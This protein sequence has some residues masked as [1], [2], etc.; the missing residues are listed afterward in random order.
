MNS[1]SNKTFSFQK[2]N[3]AISLLPKRR[4]SI[5]LPYIF[6]MLTGH[7]L[8]VLLLS[9]LILLSPTSTVLGQ[10]FSDKVIIPTNISASS[11]IDSHE[12]EKKE[13]ILEA[14]RYGDNTQTSANQYGMLPGQLPILTTKKDQTLLDVRARE[15]FD[16][17]SDETNLVI[18]G[19]IRYSE[20][21][22]G[23]GSLFIDTTMNTTCT[24]TGSLFQEPQKA[25]T[26]LDNCADRPLRRARVEL[27]VKGFLNDTFLFATKTDDSGDFLFCLHNEPDNQLDFFINVETCAD[28]EGKTCGNLDGTP[29]SFSIVTTTEDDY[30]YT[31]STSKSPAENVCTGT[32][33]WNI[34]DKRP[35]NNGG[36]HIFDL[37][38]N[39]AFDY[40]KNKV[41]WTNNFRLQ[42]RFPASKTGF[43]TPDGIVGIASGDEQD[44]DAILKA[45]SY[46][47]LYQLYG[48][49]F[50]PHNSGCPGH[51]W[52]VSSD[53]GCAWVHGWAYFLQAAMQDDPLFI[54]T[55]SQGAPPDV[56]I[57]LEMP[58]PTVIGGIKD[59]GAVAATLWDIMDTAVEN[60]DNFSYDFGDIW[61]IAQTKPNDLCEFIYEFEQ[62]YSPGTAL[63]HIVDHHDVSCC[64]ISLT[65]DKAPLPPGETAKVT[66]ETTFIFPDNPLEWELVPVEGWDVKAV[67]TPDGGLNEKATIT[68]VEGE[69]YVLITVTNPYFAGCMKQAVLFIGCGCGIT[70]E[71]CLLK[72]G[73]FFEVTSIAVR[74]NLG[75]TKLGESAGDIFL[76]ANIPN[77]VNATPQILK[78]FEFGND[79]E[80]LSDGNGLRQVVAPDSFVDITVIDVYS[81]TISFFDLADMGSKVNGFYEV[82]VGA[83]PIVTWTIENPD[84]SPTVYNRLKMTENKDG[85]T[86]ISEYVWDESESTWSLSR[87]NGLQ[88]I[89]R[90]EEMVGPN[91]VV[92]ETI[93]DGTNVIASKVRTTYADIPYNGGSAEEI[94]EIVEDPDNVALTTTREWYQNPCAAGSCGK[95]KS[96][97]N[98]D[99]SW[100]RY[101]Y[102]S[103]GRK[104]VEIRSW[105][106]APSSASAASARAIYYSYIAQHAN[107]SQAAEDARLPRKVA[108][109]ILGNVVAETYYVYINGTDGSRTEIVE[110][111]SG[112]EAGYGASG[113]LRTTTEYYP[114]DTAS[115]DSWRIKSITYPDGRKEEYTYEYGTYTPDPN[116]D[117]PG[118]FASGSGT[119]IR[120]QVVHGTTTQTEGIAFKTTMERRITNSLGDMLLQEIYVYVGSGYQRIQWTVQIHDKFGHILT[121]SNSD[122][123]KSESTWDCCGKSSD[124]DSQGI[125]RSFD[126]DDLNRLNAETKSAASDITTTY[127][128]DAVGRRLTQT[129]SAGGLSQSSSSVYD[130][131]GRLKQTIDTA[132]LVTNYNYTA[133]GRITTVTRPGGATEITESYMDGQT[134]SI[135]GTA[136]IP[137]Y[138]SYG[139]NPGG[140]QWT[141]LN[142][143][144]E[145][146]PMWEKTIID[147][148]DRTIK[149]EKPGFTGIEITENTYNDDGH[150][151]ETATTGQ[152]DTIYTYDEIGNQI[153]G[154]LDLD[155][156]GSLDKASNDRISE[157]QTRYTQLEGSWWQESIQKVYA[158]DSN[159]TATIT[160]IHLT[161]LTGFGSGGLISEDVA[162]DI[163]G[164]RTV[165]Q[166][167][168]DRASKT[169]TNITAFSD[170]NIYAVS[171]SV[172][173]LLTS[174]QSKTGVN[175][176]YSYDALGR[177][178]GITDPRTGTSVT[179]YNN[180]GQVDYIED[181][182]QNRTQYTYD[183]NTGWKITETNAL[184]KVTRYE[185]NNRGQLVRIW[186]D[187]VYPVEY[188]YDDFERMTQMHT[189]R[190]GTG[191][192]G[193][194]W[195]TGM[196]GFA[197][198]TKWYYQES[199]SLLTSKEDPNGQS[200]SYTY[201]F[202]GKLATRTWARTDGVNP[203]VTTYTY[204]P[205]TGELMKIDYSDSTPD[206]TFTYDRLGRQ[207][208]ITDAAG[209]R[210]F[211]YNRN[212]QLESESITGLYDQIFTHSYET[213]VV[214]GRNTGFT[215]GNGYSVSYGYDDVGRFNSIAWN[216]AN[217]SDKLLYTYLENSDLLSQLTTNN[218]QRTTYDYDPNRNLRT[219][220]KN[221][222]GANLI[223]QYDY[224]YDELGRKSSVTNS[225]QAF[226]IV[227]SAF[228]IYDYND[229]NELIESA[230]YQGENVSDI[231][232][233]I[234]N[235]YRS[236]N[237]DPIGNR[238]QITEGLDTGTYISNALNQYTNH[239]LPRGGTYNFTYDSDGDLTAISDG[240]TTTYYQYNAENRLIAVQPKNPVD[241]DTKSEFTYDYM[242]RR[243]QKIVYIF[244]SGEWTFDSEKRFIYNDWNLIGELRVGRVG[245]SD[246]YY[247]WGLD[248]SGTLQGAGGIGGL[249][250]TVEVFSSDSDRDGDVD[251]SD[252]AVLINNTDLTDLSK[253]SSNFGKLN[254]PSASD[255]CYYLYDN[256][257]NVCQL[258][259]AVTGELVGHYEYDPF[260]NEIGTIGSLSEENPFRFSTKYFDGETGVY[261]YGYRYYS[262]E[263]GRWLNRDPIGEEEA[264]NIYAFLFND[265]IGLFD[266]LGLTSA[267][268][269]C[270]CGPDVTKWFYKEAEAHIAKTQASQNKSWVERVPAFQDQ[271]AYDMAYK[272]MDFTVK[273]CGTGSCRHTVWLA[274][275]CLRKNQ[276][277]NI[278]FMI[279]GTIYPPGWPYDTSMKV[280]K[281][282]YSLGR[283][284]DKDH[285]HAK[286]MFGKYAGKR[287]RDN[288]AAF[289]VGMALGYQRSQGSSW[290]VEVFSRSLER[291]IRQ[292]LEDITFITIND[293]YSTA[294]CQRCKAE[295]A[296]EWKG[297][298]SF[299]ARKALESTYSE[300]LREHY[301]YSAPITFPV[302]SYD[303]WLQMN[304]EDYT[305][306]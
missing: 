148:L 266:L 203:I 151:V 196:S 240:T 84:A 76:E 183:P 133:G 229:R 174:Q 153:L 206:I 125:S 112:P 34:I 181:P 104:I 303:D 256:N 136:V 299:D 90:K 262:P 231:N 110:H 198:I 55:P 167:F 36:Q 222:F 272:W 207:K 29:I 82:N 67:I 96:Q 200:V 205:D 44:P 264:V 204:D 129:T 143:G 87:G 217:V 257:G 155:H 271:A 113:N 160:G 105:L 280:A 132:S 150:L 285:P 295:G 11:Q 302:T 8:N 228:N 171:V 20:P 130:I 164:N 86:R 47:V 59:E 193:D 52:G 245:L 100:V 63:N 15:A 126:Y 128:Y 4:L 116:P 39:D 249:I 190:E 6:K 281:K 117:L 124:T 195:P 37:L 243:V 35:Q 12:A 246:K 276:L 259:D 278:M 24:S 88:L 156:N 236:Y 64:D 122:G 62:S 120:E 139:A 49:S 141:K 51:D 301:K 123:T 267:E 293:G 109:E 306:D 161:R 45:Y 218:G 165:D 241:G 185:Y 135:T 253:F 13:Y 284:Y 101:E 223:S 72:G 260:G 250:A 173:D 157:T 230:R 144:S 226:A 213:S 7:L 5:N 119:D 68:D 219:S 140:T 189:W 292:R 220:V 27:W 238:K 177:R 14:D 89:T 159:S 287:R 300:F 142:L 61:S 239:N 242:G 131:A 60:W 180:K 254:E 252:L 209:S 38:A 290:D 227:N 118:T 283:V 42:V 65:I 234:I 53:P 166:V 263:L 214:K 91:R 97:I 304:Y 17:C 184:G 199:T 170:S 279:V 69:G 289:E 93:E 215:L 162:I 40:L 232:N 208:T 158:E 23:D 282:G 134:K 194:A 18:S 78:V 258:V 114:H 297:K 94:I 152:A 103:L 187:A 261:Y 46:F 83:I 41:N 95:L 182:V 294:R 137:Y 176:T 286:K 186:G 77:P 244:K 48:K 255:F 102:D 163:H 121:V 138:Y 30:I 19:N 225:G 57:D 71:M 92:T 270:M 74:F 73:A 107:D 269:D 192:D 288:W 251:G 172:N 25:F 221:E 127:T 178:T 275:I 305:Q 81:Y 54:D 237:Y 233:P 99:G 22:C 28:G 191:W 2:S 247:V 273:G 58:N 235:E 188:V 197:D 201:T 274:G 291:E 248:L 1:V 147:M 79:L 31:T 146:S 149:Q 115:A 224:Q 98:P 56:Q 3:I 33:H 212:L 154:G 32:V 26:S 175:I 85:R 21:G 268:T 66:A 16:I 210:T 111:S 169:E 202:D 298:S 80:I 296:D 277:G 211:S 70:S 106:D 179:S 10:S 50:P 9:I 108:E 168:I 145:N 216:V 75:R 43:T 265:P